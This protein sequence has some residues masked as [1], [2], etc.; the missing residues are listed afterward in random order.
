MFSVLRWLPYRALPIIS[1]AI[2]T[3]I[4]IITFLAL[5]KGDF[6]PPGGLL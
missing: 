3:I 2:V 6:R 5:T 4:T 1:D